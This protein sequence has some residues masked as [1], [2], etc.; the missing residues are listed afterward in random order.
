VVTDMPLEGLEVAT[1]R[2]KAEGLRSLGAVAAS[3]RHF[4]FAER[5]FDAIVHV[6]LIC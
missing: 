1:R 6:D 5:S 4:P 2:A 3:A